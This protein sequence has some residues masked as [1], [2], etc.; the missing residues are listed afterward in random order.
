MGND[1][2]VPFPDFLSFIL[3]PSIKPMLLQIG[4]TSP[5]ENLFYLF[6]IIHEISMILISLLHLTRGGA[7]M[8]DLK[9][10]KC[11]YNIQ[12]IIFN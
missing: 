6:V 8:D 9:C 2:Y 7:C 11:K 5:C 12:R 3:T 10:H 4:V 1:L